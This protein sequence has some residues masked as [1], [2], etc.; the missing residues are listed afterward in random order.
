MLRSIPVPEEFRLARTGKGMH[1]RYATLALQVNT[2][3][4]HKIFSIFQPCKHLFQHLQCQYVDSTRTAQAEEESRMFFCIFISMP[5]KIITIN[6]A[7]SVICPY[8]IML[9]PVGLIDA[10]CQR[11]YLC[12]I[13]IHTILRYLKK[14]SPGGPWNQWLRAGRIA[15]I[16]NC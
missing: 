6:L 11:F 12:I 2:A 5:L 8:K 10:Y 16:N 3:H 14:S 7:P 1:L 4:H 9:T 13:Q 15:S